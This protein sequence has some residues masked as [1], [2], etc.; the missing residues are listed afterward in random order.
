MP[1]TKIVLFVLCM[2]LDV[3]A[4]IA[5]KINTTKATMQP[6]VDTFANKAKAVDSL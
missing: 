3:E 6:V 5:P 4:F 1:L 2:I